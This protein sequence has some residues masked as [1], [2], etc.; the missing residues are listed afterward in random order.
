MS[1]LILE[2]KQKALRAAEL[3]NRLEEVELEQKKAVNEAETIIKEQVNN[4]I[5]DQKS[6]IEGFKE[7]I[8]KLPHGILN[9]L[10]SNPNDKSKIDS[11]TINDLFILTNLD[12]LKQSN[13]TSNLI[14]SLNTKISPLSIVTNETGELNLIEKNLSS[15]VEKTHIIP[16]IIVLQKQ[17]KTK[18]LK[19]KVI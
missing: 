3:Q 10:I 15:I 14:D 13:Y 18:Y 7:I 17:M 8:T 2:A 1:N 16:K 6:S 9:I 4:A 19:E 11:L 12:N 5:N